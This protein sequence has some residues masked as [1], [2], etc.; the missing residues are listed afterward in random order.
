[1]PGGVSSLAINR[2]DRKLLLGAGLVFALLIICALALGS[3]E[4]GQVE[5]PSSYSSSS[6]GAKA[7]YL[8]LSDSGYKIQRWEKPLSVLP[9][10]AAK[11]LILAE[12][13]EAPT[14]EER[15]RLRAFLSEGGRI[16]ATGMF[17]GSFLPES[18]SVP[19]FVSGQVW[20]TA[21]RLAPSAITRAAPQIT[22]APSAYWR[23]FS[24]GTPLYGDGDHALVVRYPFGRGE[25]LWWASATPLTNAGLKEPGNLEFFLAC[26][27]DSKNEILWDE[28]IHGY[29][30][31]LGASIAH[32]AVK[33][34]FLQ[35]ALLAAAILATFSRRSAPA[36]VPVSQS[37]LSPM[38]FVETLGSLYA[39]AGSASIAVDIGYRRFRYWLA[40]RLG[41]PGN[42]SAEQL[43]LASGDHWNVGDRFLLTLKNCEAATPNSSLKPEDAL[44]LLQELDEYAIQMNLFQATRK[45]KS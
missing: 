43:A 40:R 34:L 18:H 15:D 5:Y 7:A 2:K 26:L 42:A 37:R 19:D 12:P 13:T 32:S 14:R 8:L 39:Q 24:A 38:E 4:H 44:H 9:Y 35:F 21:N 27:G 33:W 36:C 20:K 25:V 29:R 31:T 3:G 11:T 17:A 16:I 10:A 41:M 28:Y 22:L 1:V 6:G 45:E 23:S 30:Q